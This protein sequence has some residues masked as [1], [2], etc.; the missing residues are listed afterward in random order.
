MTESAVESTHTHTRLCQ[1]ILVSGA[2]ASNSPTCTYREGVQL[3]HVCF[4]RRKDSSAL[5]HPPQAGPPLLDRRHSHS[6]LLCS[7]FLLHAI[8]TETEPQT[9]ANKQKLYVQDRLTVPI[10]TVIVSSLL[11]PLVSS[12]LVFS[13]LVSS[14]LF[15]FHSSVVSFPSLSFPCAVLSVCQNNWATHCRQSWRPGAAHNSA[16]IPAA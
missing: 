5:T 11:S 10:A 4:I 1:G 13:P 2:T 15:I 7:F 3:W 14:P 16:H 9:H 12:P 8:P 6:P